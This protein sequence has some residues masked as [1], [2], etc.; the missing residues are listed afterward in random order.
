VTGAGG[1]SLTP[2]PTY[3]NNV[4]A[5]LATASYAFAP[6]AN[7]AGSNASDTFTIGK[8][9]ATFTVTP[10]NVTY[11]GLPHTATVSAITG[12]NGETG[13]T[14]GTV[15]VNATTHT[16]AGTYASDSWT[17]TGGPN[18][19]NQGPITITDTINKANATCTINGFTGVYDGLA[20]G[21]S[22][23]CTGVLGETLSGLNLGASF[24][25]VPGGTAAWVFTDATGNYNNS[26]GSVLIVITTAYCFTGFLAP[27]DGSV[28]AGNGGSFANP[29]RAFKLGSTVPVKFSINSLS[30][31][32]CG[33]PVTTGIHTLQAVK[34]SN[35]TDQDAAIDAT[36]TD[37]ATTGSQFKLTGTEWHFNM[38]TKT[39]FSVG[40]WLLKATLQDG[41][42]KTVWITIKK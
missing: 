28:E 4:N 12:V 40:T 39:G 2:A 33:A 18:Y 35:S 27:I 41:S 26:S 15:N 25:L 17:F 38:S 23:S 29:V 16:S 10:Y 11:D 31:A 1:L 5:G 19:N 24:T 6:S 36:P 13:A 32:T 14:V 34:Y 42:V 20:H 30:G 7:H 9:N 22:G 37:E 3:V 8:A 21:A